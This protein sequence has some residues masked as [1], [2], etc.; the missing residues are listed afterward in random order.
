MKRLKMAPRGQMTRQKGLLERAERDRMVME[1]F[2]SSHSDRIMSLRMLKEAGIETYAFVGPILPGLTD[3]DKVFSDLAGKV[4]VVLVDKLNTRH[5]ASRLSGLTSR[6]YPHLL[7]GTDWHGIRK[8]VEDAAR[9]N[10]I[11]ANIIF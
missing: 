8:K 4:K 5:C 1:P 7:N 10:G 2:A 6:D 9:S 11:K 3:I